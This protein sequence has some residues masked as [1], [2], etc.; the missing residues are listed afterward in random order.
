MVA[1]GVTTDGAV[2]ET[3]VLKAFAKW[4][5]PAVGRVHSWNARLATTFMAAAA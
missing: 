4:P 5:P 3:S 2:S 1:I